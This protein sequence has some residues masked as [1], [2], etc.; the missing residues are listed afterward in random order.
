MG[1]AAARRAVHLST[2]S[3]R[4][5]TSG[6]SSRWPRPPTRKS[7]RSCEAFLGARVDGEGAEQYLHRHAG[8]EPPSTDEVPLLLRHDRRDPLRAIRDRARAG[9]RVAHRLE[10]VQGPAVRRGWDR[11]RA[12]LRRRPPGGRAP[13][14][15]VRVP[16]DGDPDDRER[17]GRARAVQLPRRRGDLRRGPALERHVRRRTSTVLG[18]PSTRLGEPVHACS[19]SWPTP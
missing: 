1:D 12:V 19:R 18:R 17:T 10:R 9:P 16:D 15:R 11:G 6:R 7:P 4:I 13:R 14:A 3:T 8:E 2:T 5:S